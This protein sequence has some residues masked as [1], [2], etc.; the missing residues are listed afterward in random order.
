M[1][2]SDMVGLTFILFFFLLSITLIAMR[3]FRHR[4]TMAMINK[5]AMPPSVVRELTKKRNG[6]AFLSWGIIVVAL[7]LSMVCFV[8]PFAFLSVSQVSSSE[9]SVL[10]LGLLALPS[11]LA[12]FVGVGLII[13][14]Y[15]TRPTTNGE[16]VQAEVLEDFAEVESEPSDYKVPSA[17]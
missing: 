1:V 12:L 14:Y 4:E 11:L 10:S 6:K 17:K 16:S 3:W 13:V 8:V 5:G 15:V 7:G 9:D 2:G